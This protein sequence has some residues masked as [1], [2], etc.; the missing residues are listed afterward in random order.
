MFGGKM[1]GFI[2]DVQPPIGL[3]APRYKCQWDNGEGSGVLLSSD[4]EILSK[5]E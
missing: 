3:L 2:I 5:K 1:K 4:L